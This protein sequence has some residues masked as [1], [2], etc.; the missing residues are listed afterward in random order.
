MAG[1]LKP[2]R[3]EQIKAR[4][5]AF[6]PYI[7]QF[8]A[9]SAGENTPDSIYAGLVEENMQLFTFEGERGL[10]GL[11]VT[12]ITEFPTGKVLQIVGCAGEGILETVDDILVLEAW[13]RYIGCKKIRIDGRP[14]WERE[15]SPFG[16]RKQYVVLMK[17]L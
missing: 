1:N 15:L 8:I 9:V 10:F 13:G 3:P 11:V 2:Q 16:W 12:E 14:G 7:A 5:D 17:D 6:K 4:W